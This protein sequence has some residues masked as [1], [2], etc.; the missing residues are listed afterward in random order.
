MANT[1]LRQAIDRWERE[2]RID[3]ARAASLQEVLSTD[4]ARTLLKHMGAHLV[5]SVALAIPIP[6][7]RSAARFIW[8]LAFRLH[9]LYALIRGRMT[10]E[11]YHAAASIHTIPVM[12]LALVPGFGAIAYAASATMMKKGLGRMLIDESA[13]RLPFR[14]YCRLRL[15][16]L[17][18]PRPQNPHSVTTL[19]V[20]LPVA[21]R[22]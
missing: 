11:E 6:G 9:A 3:S 12:L 15:A 1:F 19:T 10:R 20:P 18:A 13:S 22:C 5:L 16:R 2:G 8:S 7:L 14:L 4:E 21:R 17:I